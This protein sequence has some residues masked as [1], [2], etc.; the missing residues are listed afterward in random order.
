MGGGRTH[1]FT[2]WVECPYGSIVPIPARPETG[3]PAQRRSAWRG[4]SL[5]ARFALATLI[6]LSGVSV[7][8]YWQLARRERDR[9]VS[10]KIAAGEMLADVFARSIQGPLEFRDEDGLDAELKN[11]DGNV[12][13]RS[14]AVWADGK[15]P[16]ARLRAP[17]DAPAPKGDSVYAGA[18]TI[19]LS[20]RVQSR[21]GELIGEV[22]IEMSLDGELAAYRRTRLDFLVG[23][24]VLALGTSA[25]LV[26]VARRQI[27]LPLRRVA[28]AAA[29]IER[30]EL[31]ARAA[32]TQRDEIGDLAFAFNRM[33]DALEDREQ[34][35]EA[36]TRNLRELVDHMRQAIVAFDASGC[37]VS[38][39]SR[40]ALRIFGSGDLRGHLVR[41]LLFGD[42]PQFDVEVQA[43]DEW[44]ELAFATEPTDWERLAEYAPK[45][46]VVGPQKIPVTLEFRPI[47]RQ[48]RVLQVMLLA[49]DVSHERTLERT[50][51]TKEAEYD[52]RLR[53]MRRLL[54]G[55]S[56]AFVAFIESAQTRLCSSIAVVEQC[57]ELLPSAT[58]DGL[59]R[60]AHTVRGEARAFD[61]RE[62]EKE[63][64]SIEEELDELRANAR[65]DG[66]QL[67]T[68]LQAK[69]VGGFR[70][71]LATLE[72]ERDLFTEASPVGKAIFNQATVQRQDLRAIAEYAERTGGEVKRLVER[73]LSRPLGECAAGVLESAP[74]WAAAEEKLVQ[75]VVDNGD[76]GVAPA[77]LPVLPGILTN[78]VRNAIAHGIE[79]PD[80]RQAA[81]KPPEGIVRIGAARDMERGTCI[82]V[83]DDGRGLDA[84]AI[85]RAA[86]DA[87]GAVE[88]AIF[89]PGVS[90][91]ETADPLAGRGV[92]LDAVRSE[93]A[94]IG[95]GVMVATEPG[96]FTRFVLSPVKNRVSMAV[97]ATEVGAA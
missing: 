35:L 25:M 27:V 46:V 60:A 81:G 95:Y 86:P 29:A 18:N 56:Q 10:G 21:A 84:R 4:L 55:G 12:N 5:G 73:L 93:L 59:F 64:E 3:S 20:R 22:Q 6:V 39:A 44:R 34:R 63:L 74:A 76:F 30:G 72:R 36:V 82:V 51:E 31:S 8:L 33:A 50:V 90:T 80:E 48:G 2:R 16:I 1:I 79:R 47:V 77:L 67:T 58:I 66:H 87:A 62:L 28:F 17:A 40:E 14:V 94:A 54:V 92:G 11:L 32:N 49:T 13:V 78:L 83:E 88:E 85:R 24:A 70:S 42:A 53:A 68:S 45:E 89:S 97:E 69:C 91:R 43:F 7:I 9:L 38:E 61:M 96:R 57:G 19:W 75:L 23:A 52:K 26:A 65:G 41:D 71:A 15:E 37:V